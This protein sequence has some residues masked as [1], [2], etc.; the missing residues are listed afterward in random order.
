LNRVFASKF[1]VFPAPFDVSRSFKKQGIVMELMD[2][3]KKTGRAVERAFMPAD[4][5]AEM[6]ILDKLKLEHDEVL[7]LLADLVDTD[8]ARE[9]KMIFKKIK[10]ALV[11]HARA[12][13]KIVYDAIIAQKDKFQQIDGEEGYIEHDLADK[14]LATLGK[15][16]NASSPEFSAAAKVLKELL[17]HHIQEE[18]RNVWRDVR[19]RFNEDER[20]DMNRRFEAAKKKVRIPA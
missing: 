9:R 7:D 19:D 15:I 5:N 13:E 14:M 11:P 2:S 10:A 8:N 20:M 17:E 6:D 4:K 12:E 1:Y 3:L 18:E 16:T